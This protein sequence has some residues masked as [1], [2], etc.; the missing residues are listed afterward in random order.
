[1]GVDHR[2]E[3]NENNKELK[4]L[5]MDLMQMSSPTFFKA[6]IKQLKQ[7]MYNACVMS[8]CISSPRASLKNMPGHGGDR[9]YIT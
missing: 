4:W 6:D 5:S 1:V 3:V 2:T 7:Y 9:T 8:E